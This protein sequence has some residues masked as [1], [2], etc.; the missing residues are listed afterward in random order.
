[1]KKTVRSYI[2][3][4]ETD[5]LVC[6]QRG[7]QLAFQEL[8]NRYSGKIYRNI[9]R[10]IK[11]AEMADDILQ[12][13]FIKIWDKRLMIDSDKSFKLY[14]AQIAR[15]AV[16]DCFRETARDKVM[17]SKMILLN[18]A[19]YSHIEQWLYDKEN[20]A[21]LEEAVDQLPPRR[22]QIYQLC[23]LEGHS[24]DQVSEI[25]GIS[26][27]T[28]NDHIVKAS[29]TLREYLIDT[30]YYMPLILFLLGKHH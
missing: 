25:L 20:K 9:L 1:M 13:V 17:I 6:L 24:Y 27:S 29:K 22:K 30:R 16:Y 7:D 19:S 5:L 2:D 21:I 10:M 4:S 14:I 8:Y 12:V 15:N 3:W 28:I 26:P 11:S 18:E 23:K